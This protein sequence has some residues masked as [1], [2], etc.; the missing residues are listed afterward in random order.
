MNAKDIWQ[1]LGPLARSWGAEEELQAQLPVLHWSST[2]LSHLAR[3]LYVDRG[4]LHLAVDNHVVAAELNLL[5]GKVLARLEEVAPGGGV[6][7]LRFQIRA[8]GVPRA[9]IAVRPPGPDEVRAARDEIPEGLPA[10]LAAVCAR[11]IAWARARER[12][13]LAAGGWR[14]PGCGVARAEGQTSCPECG[15]EGPPPHR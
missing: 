9:E 3:P 12:A 2:G 6:V 1:W 14:C 7:D 5:K 4:V 8:R 11:L 13:L 10:T 15:I